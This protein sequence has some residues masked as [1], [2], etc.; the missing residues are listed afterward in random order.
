LFYRR[1][2]FYEKGVENVIISEGI[3]T[4]YRHAFARSDLLS[5]RIPATVTR[6]ESGA[7]WKNHIPEGVTVIGDSAFSKQ[8]ADPR[9]PAA[10][11][12][13]NRLLCLYR[14]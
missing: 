6:I 4:I 7:F 1:G 5:V 14:Q 12:Q 8:P 9:D 10:G 11:G 13:K 3:T 2:I